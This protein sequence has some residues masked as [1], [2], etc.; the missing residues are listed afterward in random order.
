MMKKLVDI[1]CIIYYIIFN[2]LMKLT[3]H[4][5]GTNMSDKKTV[6]IDEGHLA[7]LLAKAEKMDKTA[8]QRTSYNLRRNAT[9]NVILAKASKA[10]I[11][12][13]AKEIEDEIRRMS[14]K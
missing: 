2:T 10:G 12:A 4:M 7:E 3:H 9:H 6:T 5:K 11:V 14:S 8:A 1:E 13:T